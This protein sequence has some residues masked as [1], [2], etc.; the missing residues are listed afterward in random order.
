MAR[1]VNQMTA[2]IHGSRG[3][4]T[5]L[6]PIRPENKPDSWET[7]ALKSFEKGVK[8]VSSL[9][10]IEDKEYMRLMRPFVVEKSCLKCHGAQGYKEGDIR[11]GISVSVP[12]EPL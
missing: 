12:M 5:S 10:K 8:E 7:A 1:Q 9:E 6:N 3:H 2:G 11:G 4:I